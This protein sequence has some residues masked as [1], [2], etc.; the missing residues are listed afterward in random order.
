MGHPT[1]AQ[2]R[3]VLTRAGIRASKKTPSRVKGLP[4]TS[5]GFIVDGGGDVPVTVSYTCGSTRRTT[6]DRIAGPL[7]RIIAALTDSGYAVEDT[8]AARG[9]VLTV[10]H[11][12]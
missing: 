3:R 4:L 2:I 6:D 12:E 10:T 7:S 5:E 1:R 9:R 8:C 11:P